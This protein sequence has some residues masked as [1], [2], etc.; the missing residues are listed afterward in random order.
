MPIKLSNSAAALWAKKHTEDGQGYWLPL[1]AHLIDTK[2]VINYLYYHWLNEAQRTILRQAFSEVEIQKL[3]KFVGFIHDL[4]KATPAFQIKRSYRYNQNPELDHRL[5]EQLL[6]NGFEELDELILTS[7]NKSPHALAGEAILE[8]LG[9]PTS[10]GAII[11]GHHGTPARKSPIRQIKGKTLSDPGLYQANYWQDDLDSNSKIAIRWQTVQRELFEMGLTQAGYQSVQELPVDLTKPQAVLVEGLLIMADWLA[12]SE[13]LNDDRTQPLFPLIR[14]D[15]TWRDLDYSERFQTA[16][17]NWQLTDQWQPLPVTDEAALYQKRWGFSKIRPVQAQMTAAIGRLKNPGVVIVEAPMGLGKTE[18]A[19]AAAEQLAA[20]TGRTGLF[21]G[22]PTQATANAMFDRVRAWTDSLATEE[23]LD[24]NLRLQHGKA[25]NNQAFRNLPHT[26]NIG[27]DDEGQ[28]LSLAGQAIVNDWFT[29]KKAMLSDFTVATIDHLL[30]MGL[31][32]KHLFLRHLG[33]SGK[34]VIIDEA[35]AYSV[36]MDSYLQK[37][38]EWL[39]AYHVPLI[40]LSATLPK[41]KR[42]NLIQAYAKGKYGRKHQLK[43]LDGWEATTAYPLLTMLDGD[44]VKQVTEF[45]KQPDQP[46]Q[47]V[48][49]ELSDQALIDQLAQTLRDGGVAGLIVNTVRRAQ[50]LAQ[51]AQNTYPEIPIM[52][53]HSQFLAADREKKERALQKAIGKH[54]H[55]P[56]RLLVIGTQVLEQSLDIDFDVMYTDIAPV[57]LL[58]QRA[59]RLHR[60]AIERPVQF[61]QPVLHLL[62][63]EDYGEYG[64]ANTAIYGN[65]LLKKTDYFL[66]EVVHLPSDISPLVQKV[67][68]PATNDQV[69]AIEADYQLS[70]QQA[71]QKKCRAK[72]FQISTPWIHSLYK[73][74]D[75]GQDNLTDEHAN[76]AVR[77]IDETLEVILLQEQKTAAGQVQSTLLDGTPLTQANSEQIAAQTI[78]LP[79]MITPTSKKVEELINQLESQTSQRY[80]AWQ[81]DSWLRGSLV[82]QLDEHR[83]VQLADCQLRYSPVSGLHCER[84]TR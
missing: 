33:L 51:L 13:Y 41:A 27:S 79:H 2:N 9:V 21:I 54:G 76:A 42:N 37:A 17:T 83:S 28:T 3:I 55:R 49:E 81:T 74:L 5:M 35:H 31:K 61:K 80:P 77:D 78:R 57:D 46:L 32:Q 73:W 64:E 45:A 38:V 23:G 22:L 16:M 58:L 72:V 11:G 48:R 20:K 84:S 66:G 15:Q 52:V 24:L 40:V 53:L 67:Y 10:I 44:Q 39:G 19:L 6:T 7:T 14:V 50:Q 4:G 68:D 34:V 1:V 36:Y 26:G 29:G 43:V 69:P 8:F 47:V 56:T 18:I 65:Y 75:Y 59:G 70:Q 25:I 82:L 12:S 63:I 71:E 30:L 60:H 62:E